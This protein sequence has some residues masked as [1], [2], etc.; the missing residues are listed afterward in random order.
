MQAGLTRA[1]LHGDREAGVVHAERARDVIDK[2]VIEALP[3][4]DFNHPADPVETAAIGPS[5][6]WLEH[7]RHARQVR[8][9]ARDLEITN[10]IGIP[11]QITEPGRVRQQMAPRP[12]LFR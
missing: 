3:T 11:K 4:G 6:A 1:L 2:I 10:D 8:I 12:W 7:Q 9:A 5:G